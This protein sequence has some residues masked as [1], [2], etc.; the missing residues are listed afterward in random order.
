[1]HGRMKMVIWITLATAVVWA[2]SAAADANGTLPARDLPLLGEVA[3]AAGRLDVVFATWERV[4]TERLRAGERLGAA[5]A[6][7]RMAQHFL[8]DTALMAPGRAWLARAEAHLGGD[9]DNPVFA[10]L[11][12]IRNYLSILS[13][14]FDAARVE[15]IRS[16]IQN[17]TL[18][19]DAGKIA[20]AALSDAQSLL[21]TRSKKV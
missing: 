4:H 8:M 12:I 7:V 13:G 18:K 11:A 9:E 6:A 3:Y 21:S 5:E 16:A 14:D 2:A 10:W 17:G 15:Q 20:D 1:M 19:M